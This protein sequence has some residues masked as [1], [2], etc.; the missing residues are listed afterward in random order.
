MKEGRGGVARQGIPKGD[1]FDL[2]GGFCG[3]FALADVDA[4][5]NGEIGFFRAV[6][7]FAR[8]GADHTEAGFFADLTAEGVDEGFGRA[9]FPA[10]KRP[11]FASAVLFDHEDFTGGVLDPGHSGNLLTGFFGWNNDRGGFSNWHFGG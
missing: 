5:E 7:E 2:V 10:R 1:G 8:R 11:K 6:V 3:E 9:D 4:K